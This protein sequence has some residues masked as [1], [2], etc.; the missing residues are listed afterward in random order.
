MWNS[1]LFQMPLMA[2]FL[3]SSSPPVRSSDLIRGQEN[4]E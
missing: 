2:L 4:S 3:L 1:N